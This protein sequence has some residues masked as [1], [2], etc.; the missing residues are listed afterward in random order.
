ML[1]KSFPTASKFSMESKPNTFIS[2]CPNKT[3]SIYF[4]DTIH[5]TFVASTGLPPISDRL[6]ICPSYLFTWPSLHLGRPWKSCTVFILFTGTNVPDSFN[7]SGNEVGRTFSS[8]PMSGKATNVTPI[9]KSA[10]SQPSDVFFST[11]FTN[12]PRDDFYLVLMYYFYTYDPLYYF[13]RLAS[14]DIVH[15][16]A[17]GVFGNSFI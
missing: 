15:P 9:P 10:S 8:D 2:D 11:S 3:S 16:C 17:R 6:Q 12:R 13:G 14:S 5:R 1:L 7:A 4:S